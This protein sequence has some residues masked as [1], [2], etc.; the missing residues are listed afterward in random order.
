MPMSTTDLRIAD[1]NAM[2]ENFIGMQ[3]AGFGA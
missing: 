2:P 1:A 3:L